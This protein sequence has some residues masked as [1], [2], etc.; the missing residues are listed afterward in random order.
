M[1]EGSR[2][3]IGREKW[4]EGTIFTDIV[5]GKAVIHVDISYGSQMIMEVE[6][7]KEHRE[8][9]SGLR[10]TENLYRNTRKDRECHWK[11]H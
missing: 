4:K 3:P 9:H 11:V 2:V 1:P 5:I 10:L 7:E 6:V 8:I